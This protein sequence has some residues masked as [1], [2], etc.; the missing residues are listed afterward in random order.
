MAFSFDRG[1][2]AYLM[3]FPRPKQPRNG[4][5]TS[6][7]MRPRKGPVPPLDSRFDPRYDS[8]SFLAGEHFDP[9]MAGAPGMEFRVPP[10][11]PIGYPPHAHSSAYHPHQH[12]NLEHKPLR[13]N[14]NA[15]VP[16]YSPFTQDNMTQAS[17]GFGM[18]GPFTQ[19]AQTQSFSQTSVGGEKFAMSQDAF[20][21][22]R[23]IQ[24]QSMPESQPLLRG[25]D[26]Y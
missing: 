22:D 17:V 6:R 19:A 8:S 24:T 5:D 12:G 26:F 1:L 18:D 7:V 11:G 16:G 15:A 4:P 20:A 25:N 14:S 3:Q 2:S 9:M 23:E 21:Y 13:T 10:P